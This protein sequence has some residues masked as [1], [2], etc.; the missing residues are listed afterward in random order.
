MRALSLGRRHAMAK[1]T[2]ILPGQLKNLSIRLLASEESG[3][4]KIRV[5]SAVGRHV[6]TLAESSRA[7]GRA[8]GRAT[9]R[10]APG[11]YYYELERPGRSGS[12][13]SRA[14]RKFVVVQ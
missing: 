1:T 7:G 10:L 14:P 2:P 3:T 6:A 4:V 13:V 9:H 8:R 5:Y 12:A 11:V